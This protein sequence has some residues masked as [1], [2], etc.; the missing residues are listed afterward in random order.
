[1][2]GVLLSEDIQIVERVA[3]ILRAV[4]TFATQMKLPQPFARPP[5]ILGSATLIRATAF[6][7]AG[8]LFETPHALAQII[9][10]GMDFGGH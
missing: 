3:T 7:A 6:G 2:G 8:G 10:V 5:E 4:R 9:K 1:M